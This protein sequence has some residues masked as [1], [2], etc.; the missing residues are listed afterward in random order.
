VTLRS[1]PTRAAVVIPVAPD[2]EV[3]VIRRT[4]TCPRAP[5]HWNFPGGYVEDHEDTVDGALRELREETGLRAPREALRL[6][7]SYRADALISVLVVPVARKFVPQDQDGEHDMYAW[8]PLDRIPQPATTG[9][10]FVA[11]HLLP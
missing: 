9:A 8:V 11:N 2:G 5:L 3:L 4:A 6:M 1:A 7:F 10:L